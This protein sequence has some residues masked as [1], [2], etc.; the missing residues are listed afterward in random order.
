MLSVEE[1]MKILNLNQT[2]RH[3][4]REE[5][6]EILKWVNMICEIEFKVNSQ[7]KEIKG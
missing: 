2:E 7:N 4:T 3:Y 6:K 5:S 1:S